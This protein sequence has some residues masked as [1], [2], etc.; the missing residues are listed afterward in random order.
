MWRNIIGQATYQIF[1]LFVL[2]YQAQSIPQLSLPSEVMLWTAKDHVVH[3]TIVFNAFVFCQLFNEFN[4]R[5]LGSE[6]NILR[7]ILSNATFIA[8][9][10]FTVAV[11]YLIVQY[12]GEFADTAPLSRR[13]WIFCISLG[14]FSIPWGAFL[15][16][17]PVSSYGATPEELEDEEE[18]ENVKLRHTKQTAFQMSAQ[19]VIRANSVIAGF[20]RR[21]ARANA[22]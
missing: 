22:F 21:G 18:D 12:G 3:S 15:R 16:L 1:V 19:N 13:Q 17:I 20:R 8:I 7:G 2:L 11:Q 9:M 4:A 14:A 5:K 10:T 6:F